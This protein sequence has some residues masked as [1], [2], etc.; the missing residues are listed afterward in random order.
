MS[1][2]KSFQ[3]K[4]DGVQKEGKSYARGKTIR[5]TTETGPK[6]RKGQSHVTEELLKLRKP[7]N[8]RYCCIS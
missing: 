8:R 2:K 4:S 1:F 6:D 3:G 5:K 7:G